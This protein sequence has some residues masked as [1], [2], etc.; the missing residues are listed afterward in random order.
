MDSRD[1][2]IEE[3]RALVAKQAA[4]IERLTQ[5][6]AELE[7]AL[8]KA[9]K[10]SSTSSKPPSSDITKP[11]P[12]RACGRRRYPVRG[13]QPGH[14]RQLREPLPPERVTD[15]IDYAIHAHEIQRLGLTPT[16][17]CEVRQ[18][19]ELLDAPLQVTNHRLAIYQDP[20]GSL[21]TPHVPEL[22]GPIFGPRLLATIAWLKSVGHCSYSTIETWMEDVLQVPVSRGYLA[23]LCTGPIAAS[24]HSAYHELRDAIPHQDQLGSDETSLKDN[25]KKHWVWCITAAAFSIFHIATTRSREVLETLVGTEFAGY[26]NFDYFSANRSFAWT[27]WIK[28]QY[29]W[30]HLIRDIRFLQEKHPDSNTNVWAAQLLDRARRLF[31][32]WHRRHEMTEAGLHRSMLTHRDRFLVLVRTP[33]ATKEARNLAARFALATF[34]TEDSPELQTYDLSQDYFRFMFAPGVEPT[35]N[36]SEQQI[37]HCV[38]DRRITQGTRGEPGQRYHERM[39]TAIATCKKQNR[40][41]FTFLLQSIT[42]QLHNTPAPSLLPT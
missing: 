38:I 25:G 13:G 36:H 21:Y 34:S 27:Y 11:R 4:Q 14:P 26:L 1:V 30:A 9:T 31:W 8:A 42:A 37:R 23:K 41:F 6:V 28:A 16:G 29:C 40:N 5:R 19:I 10:D 35:N 32:A 39:W 15:T 18:Q 12:Q 17:A 24:L 7:L 3:L 20:A 22:D 2:E 33:P